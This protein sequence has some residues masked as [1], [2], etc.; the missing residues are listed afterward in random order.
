MYGWGYNWGSTWGDPASGYTLASVI[1][2]SQ[3]MLGQV[4]V[5]TSRAPV[6]IL[7]KLMLAVAR[8]HAA[9]QAR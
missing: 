3:L 5:L 9:R 1:V 4:E 8:R 7:S 2:S 6:A